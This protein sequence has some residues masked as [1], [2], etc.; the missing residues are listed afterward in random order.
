MKFRKSDLN[1]NF[2][3]R[4]SILMSP[5]ISLRQHRL[6]VRCGSPAAPHHRISLMA[7]NERIPVAR[8]R[9]F[10]SQNLNVCFHRKRTFR[11]LENC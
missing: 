3:K 1:R 5:K 11:L 7:A 4:S 9:Y 2:K 8:Q 10:E 6:D